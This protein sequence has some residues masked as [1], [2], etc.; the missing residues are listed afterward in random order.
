[1]LL[2]MIIGISLT[3]EKKN[4]IKAITDDT[5]KSTFY[6]LS[7]IYYCPFLDLNSGIHAR[8]LSNNILKREY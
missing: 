4:M 5:K 6:S 7:V 1:M 3:R 2:I 8:K